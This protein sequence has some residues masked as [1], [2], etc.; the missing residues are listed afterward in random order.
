[1]MRPLLFALALLLAAPSQ[2]GELPVVPHNRTDVK[3]RSTTV[4]TQGADISVDA[5]IGAILDANN[6]P[7]SASYMGVPALLECRT[8]ER[9]PDGRVVIYQR[10]GGN[11]LVSSRHYVIVLKVDQRTDTQA[12]VSWDLVKH[13]LVNGK[14][15]GPYASALN[16]HPEAVYTPYNIG[17]WTYNKSTGTVTY[18]ASSDP[19]GEIPGWMVGEGAV[20]A[21]PLELLRVKWGVEP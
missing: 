13:D 15:V 8:L 1:M 11:T 3:S 21:F 18:S 19:G 5:F 16:A 10:T 12:K 7:M 20:T 4:S 2:A 9:L 14:F 6:Y 17:A